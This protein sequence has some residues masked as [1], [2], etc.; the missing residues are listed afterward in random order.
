MMATPPR[1]AQQAKDR[2]AGRALAVVATGQ[3]V[4]TVGELRHASY[5]GLED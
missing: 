4:T 5:N 1:R 3:T 2:H